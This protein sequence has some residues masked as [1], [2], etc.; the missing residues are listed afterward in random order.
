MKLTEFRNRFRAFLNVRNPDRAKEAFVNLALECTFNARKF[1]AGQHVYRSVPWDE[2][3]LEQSQLSYPPAE[4]VKLGRCNFEGQQILYASHHPTNTFAEQKNLVAG[5]RFG[6]SMWQ[7][8][9]DFYAVLVGFSAEEELSIITPPAERTFKSSADRHA[10][11]QFQR[12]F[13]DKGGDR[14]LQTASI[15]DFLMRRRMPVE[16]GEGSS[17]LAYASVEYPNEELLAVNF[18]FPKDFVDQHLELVAAEYVEVSSITEEKVDYKSLHKANQFDN[19]GK[20]HW[21]EQQQ[22]SIGHG[23][24]VLAEI[25]RTDMVWKMTDAA[26]GK[27]LKGMPP[28]K[29]MQF[30]EKK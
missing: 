7:A 18:A 16:F 4:F 30:S 12:L 9:R 6:L 26:T 23:E 11:N 14:Y 21:E 27:P 22:W 2:L 29:I 5:S 25:S 1:E 28:T 17:I 24:T 19:D 20:I 3:P 10:H 13:R 15:A 8:K